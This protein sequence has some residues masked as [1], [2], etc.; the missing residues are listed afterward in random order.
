MGRFSGLS[1][2][3]TFGSDNWEHWITW[4]H[5]TASLDGSLIVRRFEP[6]TDPICHLPW[7]TVW[8]FAIQNQQWI[9]L[10][11]EA[12]RTASSSEGSEP[13]PLVRYRDGTHL[14]DQLGLPR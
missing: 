12:V 11:V 13:E 2:V 10:A 3:A 14:L 6:I 5:H 7:K 1:Y 8:G 4:A 9:P